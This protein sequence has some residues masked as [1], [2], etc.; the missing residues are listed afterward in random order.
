MSSFPVQ[1]S[2]IAPV[3]TEQTLHDFFTFCGKIN[4][5][6]FNNTE[7]KTATIYFDKVS[8]AKT[9]LM[10]NGGALDGSHLSVTSNEIHPDEPH[11]AEA[12][13]SAPSTSA[14]TP[15]HQE[16]KPRSGIAAE[17]LAKGYQLSD[18]I[19]QRAIEMD[20]K[21]GISQRFLAYIRGLDQTLG[22]KVAG[23]ET[24]LSAKAINTAK[25]I[26]EKQGISTKATTYYEKAMASP[27][28]QRVYSFYTDTAKQVRDIHEEARRIADTHKPGPT[29]TPAPAEAASTST[30][31]TS[32]AK[33]KVA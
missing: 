5:I 25:S 14:D 23:P 16:D 19:L 7:P 17:Y 12:Q 22:S 27:F 32:D 1:V 33:E 31:P 2:N 21:K 29:A 8:A 4:K 28:G 9:A 30:A 10:L 3:T 11:P 26:D 6:D 13:S 15:I 20:K 24:T 18:N